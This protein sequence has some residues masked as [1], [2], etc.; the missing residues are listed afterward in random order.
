MEQS[1][2]HP[3]RRQPVAFVLLFLA[4]CASIPTACAT[5]VAAG[6]DAQ[7]AGLM[8]PV[9]SVLT[10]GNPTWETEFYDRTG[11]LMER[12]AG[13]DPNRFRAHQYPVV[14]WIY[15]YDGH[16][17]RTLVTVTERDGALMSVTAFAYDEEGHQTASVEA[18]MRGDTDG[19]FDSAEFRLYDERGSEV[20]RLLF[21][22]HDSVRKTVYKHHEEGR[23]VEKISFQDGQFS[24][25]YINR[26]DTKGDPVERFHYDAE[27]AFV[28]REAWE[29]DEEGNVIR[30]SSYGIGGS[31]ES[32]FSHRYE[33]D[34]RGNWVKRI[35]TAEVNPRTAEGRLTYVPESVTT[36][37]I[38]YYEE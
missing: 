33:F 14:K 8:G 20:R 32:Q 3:H 10:R 13:L 36:R 11:T 4:V 38:S 21:L 17:K 31:L 34:E 1:F 5:P 28:G 15:S 6:T 9:R 18:D 29:Y 7:E 35:D 37:T 30:T 12:W 23:R 25:R 26:Y 24:F 16:G 27:G 2:A 22:S 19:Q